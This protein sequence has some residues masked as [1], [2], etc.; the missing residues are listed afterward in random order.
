MGQAEAVKNW[1]RARFTASQTAVK[2]GLLSPIVPDYQP[3]VLMLNY[4]AQKACKAIAALLACLNRRIAEHCI[5]TKF[6]IYHWKRKARL[7]APSMNSGFGVLAA[8]ARLWLMCGLFRHQAVICRRR[9]ALVVFAKI[10]IT[11]L[12]WCRYQCHHLPIGAR[13]FRFWRN[14]SPIAL[15]NMLG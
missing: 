4:L 15:P 6:A 5:L 12:A 14:I 10:Y 7:C 3:N 13:I 11:G 9:L 2:N 8:I 1:P